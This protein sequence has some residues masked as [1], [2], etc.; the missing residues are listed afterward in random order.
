MKT[1]GPNLK[2]P[3]TVHCMDW[4]PQ[5]DLLA[6]EKV[7]LFV[8]HCGMNSLVE[9]CFHGTPMV[10]VPRFGDQFDNCARTLMSGAAQKLDVKVDDKETMTKKMPEVLNDP[11]YM[12]AAKGISAEMK[13]KDA[14]TLM[15]C[16]D[17]VEYF[18]KQT[19]NPT[20]GDLEGYRPIGKI[21]Y[22]EHF[23]EYLNV[24]GIQINL[25]NKLRWRSRGS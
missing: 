9:S 12:K 15:T 4:L 20:Q 3:P 14:D 6:H 17:R 16:A 18:M 24:A 7:Q 2:I 21:T 22:P 8:T 5:N 10:G 13:G 23:Q 19:V 11:K 1:L 25:E